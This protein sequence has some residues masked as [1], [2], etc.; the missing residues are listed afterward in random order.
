MKSATAAPLLGALVATVLSVGPLSSAAADSL[1]IQ[2]LQPPV[3]NDQL[4]APDDSQRQTPRRVAAP[5]KPPGNTQIIPGLTFLHKEGSTEAVLRSRERIPGAEP[6]LP[7]G[8]PI[9]DPVTVEDA[10]QRQQP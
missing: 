3:E 6:T 5:V 2:P 4:R 10:Q 1:P 8:Q 9:A 7:D